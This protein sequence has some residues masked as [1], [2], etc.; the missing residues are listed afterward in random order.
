MSG[1]NSNPSKYQDF[2]AKMY[3]YANHELK[4]LNRDDSSIVVQQIDQIE[5]WVCKIMQGVFD[6]H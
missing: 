4:K 5:K 6:F 1:K 2:V 3:N